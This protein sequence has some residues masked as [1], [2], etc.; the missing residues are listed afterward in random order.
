[1]SMAKKDRLKNLLGAITETPS[2]ELEPKGGL[3][4]LLG[5]GREQEAQETA[6]TEGNGKT[7]VPSELVRE[8]GISPEMEEKLNE[9]R[10]SKRGRPKGRGNGDPYRENRATFIV[11]KDVTRKLKYIAL[12]ETQTYKTIVGEA[13]Q[14]Y[15]ERWEKK[16]G[17]IN[18]PKK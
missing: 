1:M 7:P 8:L 9:V 2:Q 16:N 6:S 13:L 4:E 10:L 18:L 14:S 15:I 3:N 12:M 5:G 11:D 17:I